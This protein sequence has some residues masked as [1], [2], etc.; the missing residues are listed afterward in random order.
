M[1]RHKRSNMITTM[2]SMIRIMPMKAPMMR[3]NPRSLMRGKPCCTTCWIPMTGKS[4]NG[5]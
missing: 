5:R 1:Q 2:R 4:C 3:M